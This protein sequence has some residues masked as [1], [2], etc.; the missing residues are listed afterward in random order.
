MRIKRI[1]ATDIP[2]VENFIADDLKDLVVIAGPN[3]VGKTRLIDEILNYF[4]TFQPDLPGRDVTN[5]SFII[6]ATDPSEHE[7]WGQQE[8]DTTN[9]QQATTLT[10]FLRQ[11]RRR[12]NFRNSVLYYE[13]DRTIHQVMPFQFQFDLPDP[14]EEDIRW[15]LALHGLKDRW[16]D[17]QHAI[18]KKLENQRTSIGN[19]AIQLRNQGYKSMKLAFSDPMIPFNEA[20]SKLLGPKTLVKPMVSNQQLMYMDGEQQLNIESLSSGEQEVLRIAFD[21]ILRNPSHCIVFFDEPELHLHPELLSRLI[22]TLRD[23]GESNQFILATHSAELISSSLDES[24][25][26]LTPPKEDQSNQA[27][28][29]EPTGDVAEA[30]HQLGQSVGIVSLGK[31]IVLIEGSDSS[32]DK[33]TYGQI[34]KD[35]FPELVLLP[36]GGKENLSSFKTIASEV[37]DKS[38]WGIQFFMLADR[39]A[40]TETQLAVTDSFQILPRYH[41]ENYFL[42]PKILCQCFEDREDEDSWLLSVEKIDDRLRKIARDALG[43]SIS[44][45]VSKKIREAAGNVSIMPKGSHAMDVSTLVNAFSKKATDERQRIAKELDDD[46]IRLL[47]EDTYQKFETLLAN[48]SDDWKNVFPGKL[49]LSRFCHEAREDESRLKNLYI[50]KA[51]EAN[52]NPFQE[53]IDIFSSFAQA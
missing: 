34:V 47:V 3:G 20:F 46:S 32:L 38:L 4:R 43:Y 26:F 25:I 35:R 37:L 39:D 36:S 42:E 5:P 11:N 7:A 13:S 6:E 14:W 45:V 12:R 28:K 23:V 33:K 19:R 9:L 31:K 24:V 29:I 18:F 2:P 21:F 51:Q 41:L 17:T 40:A 50:R 15:E 49:I 10:N 52:I 27:V 22:M 53:I 16:G 30:L 44:L 8:L 48:P 1:S